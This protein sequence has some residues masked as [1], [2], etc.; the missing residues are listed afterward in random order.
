MTRAVRLAV[1]LF[2]LLTAY[3]APVMP[4]TRAG[5]FPLREVRAGQIAVAKSVFRGTKIE[6]FH[7]KI[8]GVIPKYDGSRSI[9][10]GRILD[11]PVVARKS[12]VIGGMSGSP[13]YLNG[14]LAG[15]ISMTYAFS[16]E[17]IAGI[18]PIEDMLEAFEQ[19]PAG[20]TE[21]TAGARLAATV[22][23]GGRTIGRVQIAPVPPSEP[24]PPGVM[25]MVPLGGLVQASGFGPR[26]L[27]QLEQDLA[28]YGLRVAAAGG[29]V[30]EKMRPPMVPGA[31]LGARLV[32]GDFD[33][34]FLGTVTM[35]EGNRL[36]GFGHPMFSR[37]DVDL[38]MTGGYVYDILPSIYLSNKIMA[39]TQVVGRVF[40][41]HQ[42]A[43]AGMLGGKADMVPVTVEVTDSDLGRSRA[44][45]VEVA[46]V[47]EL[48]PM[49][50]AATVL[51]AVDEMR[52]RVSR[53]TA[54]VRLEIEAEGKTIAREDVDYSPSDAAAVAV[55]AVLQPL[56]M[57]TENQFG[58]MRVAR[59]RVKVRTG[60]ARKTA[61]I[62]RVTISQSRAKAGDEVVL[63]VT[64]R[65]YGDAATDIPVKVR[66]PADLPKGQVRVVISRGSDADQARTAIGAPAP[67]PVNLTQLVERYLAQGRGTDL[68]VQAALPRGGASLAGE[69]LPNLPRT[70]MEALSATRPTDL[71]PLP[72]LL[73]V[74]VPTDWVLTGR[75]SLIIPVESPI[76]AVG[77][78]PRPPREAPPEEEEQ[79][80]EETRAISLLPRGLPVAPDDGGIELAAGRPGAAVRAAGDGEEKKE[81]AALTRAPEMWRQ[82]APSD[83]E[84]SKLS[85]V[86]LSGDGAL[87]L[88][89][90]TRLLSPVPADVI[91]AMAA[92]DG[93]V[94]AGTGK[95]GRIFRLAADGQLSPFAATGEMNVHALAFAPDGSLY[96]GTSPRG[97][98][99]RIS[100]DGKCELAFDSDSTYIWALAI[101]PDGAI[102]AGGGSPGRVYALK[103]DGGATVAAELPVANVLSLALGPNKDV[104]AG[105][106]DLGLIFRIAP[107]GAVT[108]VGQVAG[109]SVDGLALDS[110]GNLYATCSPGGQVYRIA[111][112]R[113]P[114]LYLETGQQTAFGLTLLPDGAP[115]IATGPKGLVVRATDRLKPELLYRPD[116]GIATAI[117]QEG[118]ALYVATSAPSVLFKLGSDR[119][120]SGIVESDVFDA[121]R[122]ATWGLVH[123]VAETPTG[124]SVT[125]ETRSGDS[126]V[127]GEGWRPWTPT[128]SNAIIS[129]AARYLQ[130]RLT[131]STDKP[132][133]SPVV[134][135]VTISRRPQNR[136]PQVTLRSP[137]PGQHLSK[138]QS[139][140]WQAQDPDKDPL[141]FRVEASPDL[142]A[143]WT[144]VA[145]NLREP[146]CDWDTTKQKDGQYLL[147]VTASD[148]LSV[149][150]NPCANDAAKVVWVD[151]TA[152]SLMLFKTSLAVDEQ[153]RATVS[154]MATDKVSPIQS[155]EYQVDD[156]EWRSLP[157]GVVESSIAAVTVVT[158]PLEAGKHKLTLRA[159]DAAGNVATESTDVEVPAL[160]ALSGAE[161]KEA[162]PPQA[163]TPQP[164]PQQPIEGE[165]ATTEE[166]QPAAEAGAALPGESAP[167]APAPQ[168]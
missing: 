159:F 156:G 135:Q 35:V 69:E 11:G 50:V 87:A 52:G 99:F 1:L 148:A 6:S 78:P 91:W 138:K 131:L 38:P 152:P 105:T 10:L 113:Q 88:S 13:V 116:S 65:P 136:P 100:S 121:Q 94:Y 24:D 29:G 145:K 62:E 153:R 123:L 19:P 37:G 107:D 119:A 45:H 158:D 15:A 39:P 82:S 18:T 111:P 31:A 7:V 49:L 164:A 161:G 56:N 114:E 160:P 149:P 104:Y 96:A 130:Y 154:A 84:T 33:L 61:A 77:G 21:A 144:E 125:V 97:K 95:D 167:A 68:V 143:T 165:K 27:K 46:R 126:P 43:A 151:N 117:A 5:I 101:A 147:R 28:P 163:A 26:A 134:R 67:A 89:L 55:P 44:F 9:I 133:L 85:N 59:V 80:E 146:K 40:R 112:E 57:L 90:D 54:R 3:P 128:V 71:R 108:A 60:Q 110:K 72:S 98:I 157:I 12:G 122:P 120:S 124:T 25:T 106:S 42:S 73:R 51:A 53:G 127:P 102:Y 74:V 47:R 16:K 36:L 81:Q 20:R 66:L 155:V 79:P 103:P 32:G 129:P 8:I 92:R 14:R 137:E 109:A 23:I 48:T 150:D 168:P 93:N 30:E 34:T 141:T 83:Y 139:M 64:I 70:A 118:G 58:E 115:A 76:S 132:D 75:Q 2:A 142:G 17:P 166:S 140:K 86:S 63:T 41:D 4:E 162:K 22:R